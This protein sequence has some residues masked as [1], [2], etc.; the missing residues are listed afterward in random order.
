MAMVFTF[1]FKFQIEEQN[2]PYA[3]SF[4]YHIHQSFVLRGT[5]KQ[6]FNWQSVNSIVALIYTGSHL[7]NK[8]TSNQ[9]KSNREWY[10]LNNYQSFKLFIYFNGLYH[11]YQN[12]LYRSQPLTLR[13]GMYIYN[14]SNCRNKEQRIII[15][16][17]PELFLAIRGLKDL[18]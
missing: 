16:F 13:L 2:C 9:N 5:C 14:F 8:C 18:A 12:I 17:F 1:V 4:A 3:S 7:F 10:V 15:Y 6:A 11:L